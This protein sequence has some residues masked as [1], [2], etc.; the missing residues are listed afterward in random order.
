ML[1]TA[2]QW[3]SVVHSSITKRGGFGSASVRGRTPQVTRFHQPKPATNGQR[4]NPFPAGNALSCDQ[5]CSGNQLVEGAQPTEAPSSLKRKA[6]E[7][8]C[9]V[10]CLVLNSETQAALHFSSRR[11]IKRMK[12]QHEGQKQWNSV[13]TGG[14]FFYL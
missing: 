2:C 10:C 7:V 5:M 8:S 9:D 11:H 1:L 12:T 13:L 4:S 3:F 6:A 14:S